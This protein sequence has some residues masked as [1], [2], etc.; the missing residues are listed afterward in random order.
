[1]PL[2][3]GSFGSDGFET[4]FDLLGFSTCKCSLAGM[5]E[6]MPPKLL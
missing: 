2:N 1:M 4:E 3:G 6:F 5:L